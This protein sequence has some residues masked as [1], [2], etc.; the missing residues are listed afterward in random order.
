MMTPVEIMRLA[1]REAEAAM[2]LG[3]VPVGAVVM[4][5]GAVIGSG[6]NRREKNS[7]PVAHAEIEALVNAAQALGHWNL[8]D[9]VLYVT[10]EPCPMCAGAIVQARVREVVY[11]ADDPK[12]GAVSLGINILENEKL[13]H[14]VKISRG[15]LADES[16]ALLKKFFRQKRR[17]NGTSGKKD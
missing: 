12:G 4:K 6:R 5:D 1:L 13:N 14:R 16:S 8:S 11:A 10:L 3:D 9:S 17:E 7:S 2:E 15:P